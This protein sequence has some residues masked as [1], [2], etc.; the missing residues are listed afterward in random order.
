MIKTGTLINCDEALRAI[1]RMLEGEKV[2]AWFDSDAQ[3]P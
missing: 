3:S 1:A 2:G